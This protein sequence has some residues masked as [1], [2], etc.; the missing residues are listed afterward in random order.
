M[1]TGHLKICCELK[2]LQDC[3][4]VSVYLFSSWCLSSFLCGMSVLVLCYSSQVLS[5]FSVV[6]WVLETIISEY[7][8]M[9]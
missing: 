7:V 8:L 4:E 2:A 5:V 3:L 1:I 9:L 6:S